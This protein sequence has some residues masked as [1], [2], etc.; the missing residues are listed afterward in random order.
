M[1]ECETHSHT[2]QQQHALIAISITVSRARLF[3]LCWLTLSVLTYSQQY[4]V[5][6]AHKRMPFMQDINFI[7]EFVFRFLYIVFINHILL[8]NVA[9]SLMPSVDYF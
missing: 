7:L 1:I 3:L 9:I 5:N 4:D 6:P 2:S 8:R